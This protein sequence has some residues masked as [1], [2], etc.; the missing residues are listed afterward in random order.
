MI[1]LSTQGRPDFWLVVP[2]LAVALGSYA[3]LI[4][5]LNTL[6]MEPMGSVA[7]TASA[8]IGTAQTGGGAVLGSFVD[9]AYDGTITPFAVAMV[10]AGALAMALG[11]WARSERPS[12]RR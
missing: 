5:N 2:F 9:R 8:L 11:I 3:L 10:V 6:A 12:L 1:A 4:P 7:G